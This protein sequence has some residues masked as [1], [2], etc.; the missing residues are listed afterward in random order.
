MKIVLILSTVL[1]TFNVQVEG[2]FSVQYQWKSLSYS[3]LDSRANFNSTHP[4]PFGI[5]KHGNRMFVGMARRAPGVPVTLG[6]FNL[7]ANK[8]DPQIIAFP[9]V[10]A[11]TVNVSMQNW[12][13]F[14]TRWTKNEILSKFIVIPELDIDNATNQY[15]LTKYFYFRCGSRKVYPIQTSSCR[16]IDPE[17]TNAIGVREPVKIAP[18]CWKII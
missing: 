6:Y 13:F 2:K 7:N 8:Q 18:K 15:K 17:W 11:N 12:E 4:V 16:F 9:S 10:D 5:A 14:A 3:N 1:F